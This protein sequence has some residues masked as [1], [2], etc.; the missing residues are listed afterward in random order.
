MDLMTWAATDPETLRGAMNIVFGIVTAGR[1]AKS[2]AAVS[3]KGKEFLI[4]AKIPRE[5]RQM[6]FTWDR[7]TRTDENESIIRFMLKASALY[8]E[9]ENFDPPFLLSEEAR[10][11]R[12]YSGDG[13]DKET[14]IVAEIWTREDTWG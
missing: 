3:F 9:E 8:I 6:L 4:C 14:N 12:F 7:L 10:G 2:A 11:Y 13:K 5:S 1:K